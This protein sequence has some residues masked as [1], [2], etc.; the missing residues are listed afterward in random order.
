MRLW[1]NW[2]SSNFINSIQQITVYPSVT[3][4]SPWLGYW[5]WLLHWIEKSA[6][7]V[8]KTL[9]NLIPDVLMALLMRSTQW[10]AVKIPKKSSSNKLLFSLAYDCQSEEIMWQI[11]SEEDS[12]SK[13][14]DVQFKKLSRRHWTTTRV[15]QPLNWIKLLFIVAGDWRIAMPFSW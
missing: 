6:C 2:L 14:C 1:H 9:H 13:K 8:Y 11:F 7:S 5:A 3:E 12:H 15:T 4:T 10:I